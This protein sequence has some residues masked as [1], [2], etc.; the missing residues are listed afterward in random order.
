MADITLPLG[1][2]TTELRSL[3]RAVV[4]YTAHWDTK[5]ADLASMT[6][7]GDTEGAVTV[8]FNDGKEV[9]TLPEITGDAV[10]EARHTGSSP[11]VTIPL[12]LADAD[13][14]DVVSPIGS[15]HAGLLRQQAVTEYTL[16][17][18]PEQS[19]YIDA[20]TGYGALTYDTGV[21]W[22]VGG[23]PMTAAQTTAFKNSVWIWRGMFDRPT[24]EFT[25]AEVGKYVGEAVF[26]AMYDGDAELPDGQK[27]I[28]MGDPILAGVNIMPVAT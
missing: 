26:N 1:T 22:S 21:G 27:L 6:W 18:I 11:T 2:L 7:L 8:N 28:T 23:T 17:I 13:R 25:W 24:L 12:F 19:M 10:H 9:L 5:T 15:K 20:T 16:A 4:Y 14:R 3:D